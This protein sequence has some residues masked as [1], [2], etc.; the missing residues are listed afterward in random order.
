VSRS[1][2]AVSICRRRCG[3]GGLAAAFGISIRGEDSVAC[4]VQFEYVECDSQ[5]RVAEGW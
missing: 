5:L 3:L 1:R 2:R 4:F